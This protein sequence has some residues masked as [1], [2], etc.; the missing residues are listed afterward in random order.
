MQLL[1][2]EN[3]VNKKMSNWRFVKLAVD[4][5]TNYTNALHLKIGKLTPQKPISY[6]HI[7]EGY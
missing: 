4:S 3:L 7:I 2:N 6:T 1:M 5:M